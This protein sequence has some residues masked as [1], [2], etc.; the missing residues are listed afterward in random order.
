MIV[1]NG[2][3]LGCNPGR[4]LAAP[5]VNTTTRANWNERG[6]LM[7][8][9]TAPAASKKD[10][11]PSGMRHPQVWLLPIKPGGL[12]SRFNIEGISDLA[13][14]LAGGV[15][16]TANLAGV[17]QI[18]TAD[19]TLLGFL[20][21]V[22]VGQSDTVMSVSGLGRALAGVA[23]SGGLSGAITSVLNVVADLA[24]TSLV[25][26]DAVATLVAVAALQ[27][28]G[29]CAAFI[30]GAIAA[31][32]ALVGGG[33]ISTAVIN[34][35]TQAVTAL[36]GSGV[37]PPATLDG[38][39]VVLADL[40]GAGAFGGTAA[41]KGSMLANI[42]LVA[43]LELS[44]ESV[45]ASVKSALLG[46]ELDGFTIEEII[47]LISAV[48]LGKSSGGATAPVFRSM[49][50][51]ADRVVGEVDASGNRVNSTLSP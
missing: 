8:I 42:S 32:A 43:S 6:A 28:V 12:A 11:I 21:A 23:G 17:G 22:M 1:G 46:T 30:A 36:V 33:V 40:A 14:N 3:R 2:V 16:G 5:V 13:G 45:A 18:S 44:P 24:G 51:A 9:F 15:G 41:A 49:D 29:Q 27:G 26:A 25:G 7:N 35:V 48:L 37:V 10:G 47:K 50:D 31:D 38:L 34:A 20:A 4:S 19:A 39:G